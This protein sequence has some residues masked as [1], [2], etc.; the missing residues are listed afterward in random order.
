M[1]KDICEE[2]G[3]ARKTRRW[4]QHMLADQTELTREHVNRIEDGSTEMGLRTLER[5]AV[6]LETTAAALLQPK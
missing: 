3:V 5:V 2:V 1:A 6:A 4:T